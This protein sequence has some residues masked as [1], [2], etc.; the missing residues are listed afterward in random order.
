MANTN[1]QRTIK[2]TTNQGKWEPDKIN[3]SGTIFS[4][5]APK[6]ILLIQTITFK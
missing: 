5:Y 3:K 1:I 2:F 4:I 6:K